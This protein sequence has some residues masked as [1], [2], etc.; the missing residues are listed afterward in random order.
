M[1]DPTHISDSILLAIRNH[2]DHGMQCGSF[3]HAVLCNDLAVSIARADSYS[4]KIL[5]LIVS[6]I[7][8][9]IPAD[10]HG[11][12]AKVKAWQKRRGL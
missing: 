11:S 9:N 5:P 7:Y 1:E 10:C 6:Y 3:M 4:L 2:V 8:N 12:F